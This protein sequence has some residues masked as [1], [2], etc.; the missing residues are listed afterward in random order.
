MPVVLAVDP[1]STSLKLGV[2]ESDGEQIEERWAESRPCTWADL[3]AAGREACLGLVRAAL[4]E[5]GGAGIEIVSSRGGL[6]APGPGGV[7]AI[8]P[9]LLA[10]LAASRF[11]AHASNLGP[12]TAIEVAN[13]LGVP[14]VIVD[15][16]TTDE[17]TAEARVSGVPGVPRRSRF[18]ALNLRARARL[19]VRELGLDPARCRLAMAHLG[20]GTS[21]V[22]YRDG[23]FID[24]NDALLGEGPFS[25]SRAGTVPTAGLIDL[26]ERLGRAETERLLTAGSGFAGLVGSADLKQ[27]A[28]VG[29]PEV[30]AVAAAYRWQVV[31]ALGGMW[32]VLGGADAIVLTGAVLGWPAL[33]ADLQTQLA[34]LGKILLYPGEGELEALAAG[35]AQALLRP[36]LVHDYR[37][38]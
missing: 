26:V 34:P 1:G 9:E 29:D 11:G 16:P 32:A 27:L 13:E 8:G 14:A 33:A 30:L 2:F 12:P 18:H 22:A 7:M 38:A 5:R 23:R 3:G 37:A 24:S 35:G 20:G 21:V 25:P 17:F 10:D 31:K 19:A 15:P 6:L 4:A 28:A 36:E